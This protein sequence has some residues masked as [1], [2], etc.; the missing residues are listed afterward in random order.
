VANEKLVRSQVLDVKTRLEVASRICR[1]VRVRAKAEREEEAVRSAEVTLQE[2]TA[3]VLPLTI[4]ISMRFRSSGG[5]ERRRNGAFWWGVRK[6]GATYRASCE[7]GE[8]GRR[9]GVWSGG[10]LDDEVISSVARLR[11]TG[12]SLMV[13]TDGGLY[14]SLQC[15]L[16]FELWARVTDR[17]D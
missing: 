15:G 5:M 2:G 17:V 8:I 12:R 13:A 7:A 11:L 4:W 3:M 10:E 1:H 14:R 16:L 9:F 6:I